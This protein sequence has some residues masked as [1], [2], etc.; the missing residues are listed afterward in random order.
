MARILSACCDRVSVNTVT[1]LMHA[2]NVE[3][4]P[5]KLRSH[6]ENYMKKSSSYGAKECKFALSQLE[7]LIQYLTSLQ[8]KVSHLLIAINIAC[9]WMSKFKIRIPFR[10]IWCM[11]L[12]TFTFDCFIVH[13]LFCCFLFCMFVY[14]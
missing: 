1:S 3:I 6:F 14:F 11:F 9:S 8:I 13:L 7:M 12:H 10:L 2:M 4:T 5:S